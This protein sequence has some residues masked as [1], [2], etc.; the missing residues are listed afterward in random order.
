MPEEI[1]TDHPDRFR[2]MIVESSNPA[3]SLADSDACREAF[4]LAGT[5]GGHRRRDDRDRPAGP[6][7][8]ARGIS[9]RE[10]RSDVL[11][12][13]VPAQHLPSAPSADGAAGRARC[14]SPRSGRGWCARSAWSTTPTCEPLR[15]A[16]AEGREASPRRSCRPSAPTPMLGK[17]L[18]YRACTKPWDRL[19]PKGLSGAAALW[20]LAQKAAMTYP[21]AVRRAGP[22]RRQRVVRRD[23][24]EPARVSR[25][26]FTNTRTTSR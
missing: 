22:R 7:R 8:A 11:Q 18:P 5:D 1:L 9:V 17:V 16:A 24:G 10:G 26:P 2:A 4:E 13:R 15:R 3:H 6:L 14:P 19:C 12:S 20:G 21:D 23:P 25:S